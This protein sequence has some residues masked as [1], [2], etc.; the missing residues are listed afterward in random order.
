MMAFTV[1][2]VLVALFGVA[3]SFDLTRVPT[4]KENVSPTAE[5][6]IVGGQEADIKD[7]PFQVS[8][9]IRFSNDIEHFVCGGSIISD[10]YILTAAH[11]VSDK[12]EKTIVRAGSNWHKNGT[13]IPVAKYVRHPDYGVDNRFDSDAAV[14]KTVNPIQFTDVIK[15]VKLPVKHR[16]LKDNS[17]VALSGWGITDIGMP[18]EDRLLHVKFP[19]VNHYVCWTTATKYITRNMWCGGDFEA[20]G[21]GPCKGDSG[22]GAVQG[23]T[24][25]GIVSFGV[26][27]ALPG[28]PPVFVDVAAPSIRNFI[29]KETGL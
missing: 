13:V 15:P 3:T 12:P 18:G 25:V 1:N 7:Y 9:S 19:V 14:I 21:L 11:C 2:I 20:G 23:G 6:T 26:P 10:S 28:F 8:I 4:A 22:G 16:P 17:V 5:D 27:C 24:V 29:A